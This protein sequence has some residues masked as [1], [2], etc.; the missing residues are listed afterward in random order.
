ME[1]K[2]IS[3]ITCELCENAI[4][5]GNDLN[6]P[7]M[8]EHL[9]TCQACREFAQFQQTMLNLPMPELPTPSFESVLQ[10]M[11]RRKQQQRRRLHFIAYPLSLAAAAALVIG[12]IVFQLPGNPEHNSA[13]DY[14]IFNDSAA[15]AV[16]LEESSILM[17]WD[18]TTH[19]EQQC[20]DSMRDAQLG[21]QAWSIEV[22]NPYNE[23]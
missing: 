13:A 17:A 5:S 19:S 2:I 1:E 15:F 22:F 20:I 21:N 4:V 14:Q 8:Q 12:G 23:E 9:R 18:Q 6:D 10:E 7:A 3:S 16:A 11:H